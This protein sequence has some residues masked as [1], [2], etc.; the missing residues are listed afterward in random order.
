MPVVEME[1]P[2]GLCQ[3]K[4]RHQGNLGTYRVRWQLNG[5]CENLNFVFRPL[6]WQ[7]DTKDPLVAYI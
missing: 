3:G 6:K 4:L 2:R 5:A 1:I 7:L